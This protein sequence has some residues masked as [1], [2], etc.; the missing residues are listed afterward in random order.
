MMMEKMVK[1]L[2][3]LELLLAL[4]RR[5]NVN[6][7]VWVAEKRRKF[8][9]TNIKHSSNSLL[10]VFPQY[11]QETYIYMQT[12]R[13]AW[14]DEEMELKE[15]KREIQTCDDDNTKSF[16]SITNPP[17]FAFETY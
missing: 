6:R 1:T 13:E 5:L 15:R 2:L 9:S 10:N 17:S 12:Q 8:G 7:L 16:T 4:T 14:L 3:E 11:A